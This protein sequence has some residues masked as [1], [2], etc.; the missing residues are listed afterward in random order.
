MKQPKVAIIE[1]N[2]HHEVVGYALAALDGLAEVVAIVPSNMMALLPVST[3]LRP[4]LKTES[5][6]NTLLR[7]SEFLNS[8]DLLLVTTIPVQAPWLPML[9]SVG[10]PVVAFVHNAR[11]HFDP[12]PN[13]PQG[14]RNGLRRLLYWWRGDWERRLLADAGLA[15]VIVA[16]EA[17]R[18]YIMEHVPQ[19]PVLAVPWAIAGT[20]PMDQV[21]T[22]L[23]ERSQLRPIHCVVPGVVREKGRRWGPVIEAFAKTKRLCTLELLGDASGPAAARVLAR[24]KARLPAHV[25]L[26]T[27]S[28][29]I[30]QAAYDEAIRQADVLILPL[31]SRIE[32]G[33][34]YEMGGQTHISGAEHDQLRHNKQAWVD[35]NWQL[36]P[37]LEHLQTPY[38][39]A[40]DLKEL[41][42]SSASADSS[43]S[44]N[45]TLD[46]HQALWTGFLQTC[47]TR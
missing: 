24:F 1:F 11:Y 30:G 9:V 27:H 3:I 28:Q 8:C 35:A 23:V 44:S 37:E 33:T 6:A 22:Q 45:W 40:D 25:R 41:I 21:P 19:L 10:P 42:E 18:A 36:R 38:T 43:V 34:V 5:P 4:Q 16:S 20:A 2:E 17:M 32:Y 13:R 26:V 39:S 14:L 46:R 29:V 47:L 7:E 12:K 15:W 31:P